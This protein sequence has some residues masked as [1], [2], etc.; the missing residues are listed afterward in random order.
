MGNLEIAARH[1][2]YNYC[3]SYAT[4][5]DAVADAWRLV[6]NGQLSRDDYSAPVLSPD[7]SN[8]SECDGYAS[9]LLTRA[10]IAG[11]TA[12]IAASISVE[13]FDETR[14]F[15][16]SLIRHASGPPLDT[17]RFA[18]QTIAANKK[19]RQRLFRQGFEEGLELVEVAEIGSL[20]N[21][22][23]CL[24]PLKKSKKLKSYLVPNEVDM[25][26][27]QKIYVA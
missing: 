19:T 17:P 27:K 1:R 26:V 13:C 9:L 15:V 21:I 14:D 24:A 12:C 22:T 11:Q 2:Q 25:S 23:T 18:D 6:H 7:F 10:R 5:P 20:K 8:F 4:A 16:S 3:L